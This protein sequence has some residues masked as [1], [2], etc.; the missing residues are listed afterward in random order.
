MIKMP[1]ISVLMSIYKEEEK[2]LR[3]SIES[4]LNQSFT[5]FEFI[6][7]DD[8]PVKKLNRTIL[9]EY[10]KKDNRIIIIQNKNNLGLTKS[11][12]KGLK[13]AK[14]DY[15]ARMDGDD[16]SYKERLNI[17]LKYLESNPEYV[18]CGSFADIINKKGKIIGTYKIPTSSTEIYNYMVYHNPMIHPTLL[19]KKSILQLNNLMYNE[20]LRYSQDY[21][22]ISKLVTYGKIANIPQP[23]I[24]YRVSK[25]Q[26]SKSRIEEQRTSADIVRINCIL[27]NQHKLP[28]PITKDDFYSKKRL[29]KI[30]K[31]IEI[32][33]KKKS[34]QFYKYVTLSI[35]TN[36]KAPLPI[37]SAFRIF[38]SDNYTI[39]EKLKI[40]R[41][42]L[43][44]LFSN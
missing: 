19:I 4:M 9:E 31:H 26:I 32:S 36:F 12:N 23:L 21:E 22:L 16:I 14:G 6:I 13:I 37:K 44:N 17:Q 35:V 40:G 25:N 5:N 24:L 43:L 42:T 39:K 3:E 33:S 41:S 38:L 2:W 10:E 27:K 34:N 1:K 8:N 30:L 29:V 7:I 15:I 11:L 20:E 28:I 18:A